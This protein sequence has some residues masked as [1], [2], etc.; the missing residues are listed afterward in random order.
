[1]LKAVIFDMDGVLIDSEPIHF[2]IDKKLLSS[3]GLDVDERFLSRYVGVSNP[4]MLADVKKRFNLDYSILELLNKKSKLLLESLDEAPLQ[5]ID[6]V[7][8]L[9]CDLVSHGVLLA[10]A[11]SSPRAY[12][13]AVIKKLDMQKY[14]QV[15]VSGEELEKSKPEPDIFLRAADLLGVEPG[16]CV[17]IED[18]SPG[19]E[20]AY[21]AGIRCIGFVNPNSGSQDLSKASVTVDDMRKLNYEYICSICA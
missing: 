1:M 21:R 17:V 14:F 16:E 6:G 18:S 19:V 20:A 15:V 5:P 2:S 8:E 12:I 9:V 10:V 3:L 7:K 13:E 11:S 4:E